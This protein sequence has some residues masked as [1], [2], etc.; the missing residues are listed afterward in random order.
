MK[1]L[2]TASVTWAF[3]IG[4]LF[5]HQSQAL[6]CNGAYAQSVSQNAAEVIRLSKPVNSLGGYNRIAK[7]VV[8]VRD[9]KNPKVIFFD[10]NK[11]QYHHDFVS[12]RLGYRKSIEQFQALN[13]TGSYLNREF[14][15]GSLAIKENKGE[16]PEGM[17]ELFSGDD[18]DSSSIRFLTDVVAGSVEQFKS[19]RFHPLSDFQESQAQTALSKNRVI[20]TRDLAGFA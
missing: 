13:Y 1:F 20:L 19:I 9:P 2:K 7:F 17:I 18:M 11:F 5:S 10:T 15:S 12:R 8:D 6:V 16:K 14:I 3:L 4:P